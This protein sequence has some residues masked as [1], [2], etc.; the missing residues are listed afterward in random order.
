VTDP[1][2]AMFKGVVLSPTVEGG[3]T[4]S[5]PIIVVIGAY[6]LLHWGIRS[7]ARLVAYRSSEI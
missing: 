2:Y 6:A 7:L 5:F 1:F 4:F 3:F